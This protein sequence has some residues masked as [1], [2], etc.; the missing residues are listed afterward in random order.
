MSGPFIQFACF[1]CPLN[2]IDRRFARSNPAKTVTMLTM[3]IHENSSLRMITA[4]R[5]L[6]TGIRLP[7]KAVRPAPSI[8]ME[9]FQIKKQIT[10]APIPRYKIEP[11]NG[12]FQCTTGSMIIFPHEKGKQQNRSE[13]KRHK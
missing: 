10:D 3:C 8:L 2:F 5:L 1:N 13:Q 7:N 12:L 9:I 11:I 6:N 4:S